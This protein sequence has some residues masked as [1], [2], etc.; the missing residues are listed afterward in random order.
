MKSQILSKRFKG[1]CDIGFC[2]QSF[3]LYAKSPLISSPKRSLWNTLEWN[4]SWPESPPETSSLVFLCPNLG[5]S[6]TV[7]KTNWKFLWPKLNLLHIAYPL[8]KI[9]PLYFFSLI[10]HTIYLFN[11]EYP[12]FC[13]V[14]WIFLNLF[15]KCMWQIDQNCEWNFMSSSKLSA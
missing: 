6:A 3:Y 13:S 10:C 15:W 5:S 8:Y 2:E 9:R 12:D 4:K 14:I 7:Y 11:H 1:I